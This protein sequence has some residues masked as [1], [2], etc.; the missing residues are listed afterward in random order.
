MA[1][2]SCLED[3]AVPAQQNGMDFAVFAGWFFGLRQL[4]TAMLFLYQ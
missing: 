2:A 4:S 1:R 3:L